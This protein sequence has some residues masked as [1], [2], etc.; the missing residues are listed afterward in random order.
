VCKLY[1]DKTTA[2]AQ[3]VDDL[4]EL[5]KKFPANTV[6]QF[7]EKGLGNFSFSIVRL[8]DKIE[9]IDKM[10]IFRRSFSVP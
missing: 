3:K 10:Y 8:I 6:I 9:L 4:N 2:L 1:N 7:E 5:K